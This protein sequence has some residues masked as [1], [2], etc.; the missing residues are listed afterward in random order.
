MRDHCGDMD[1]WYRFEDVRDALGLGTRTV[2]DLLTGV[3]PSLVRSENVGQG[4]PR[5]LYHYTAHPRLT[6]GQFREQI[7]ST[8]RAVRIGNRDRVVIQSVIDWLM[9]E[10]R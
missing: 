9:G 4:R 1:N 8:I 3:S 10:E 5:K 6:L 7:L 2:R